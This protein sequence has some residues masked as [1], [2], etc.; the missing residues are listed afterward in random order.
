MSEDELIAHDSIELTLESLQ[1]G[2]ISHRT[3][4]GIM[5]LPL[6]SFRPRCP[7]CW[8][9]VAWTPWVEGLRAARCGRCSH[10]WKESQ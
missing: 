3:A 1:Y 8:S 5:Q 9:V 4:L 2:Q 7:K 10:G 6:E